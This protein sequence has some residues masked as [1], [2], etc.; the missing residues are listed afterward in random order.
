MLRHTITLGITVKEL[1]K[2]DEAEAGF[3]QAI[4]F[5]SDYAEAHNNL[6]NML[7]E[8][9]ALDEAAAS[10]RQ[11]ITLIPNYAEAH[12]NL[13]LALQGL[14]GWTKLKLALIKR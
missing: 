2:L 11:A 5:K 1:G 10:Y 4:A 12:Y 8:R 6:G 14:G 7:K 3:R 13:G 9:G